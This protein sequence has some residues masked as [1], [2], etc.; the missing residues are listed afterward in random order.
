[1]QKQKQELR[2]HVPG[3]AF[4]ELVNA[5]IASAPRTHVFGFAVSETSPTGA[6]HV[7]GEVSAVA[8]D[9]QGRLVN[10]GMPIVVYPGKHE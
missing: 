3:A 9:P 1:M 10:T 5:Q 7:G 8:P 2:Q 6:T 4:G